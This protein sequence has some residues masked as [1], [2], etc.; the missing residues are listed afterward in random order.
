[1]I[2]G[3]DEAISLLRGGSLFCIWPTQQTQVFLGKGWRAARGYGKRRII[4][5]HRQGKRRRSHTNPIS[6]RVNCAAIGRTALPPSEQA[7]R[8]PSAEQLQAIEVGANGGGICFSMHAGN[9]LP[10]TEPSVRS[11][12]LCVRSPSTPLVGWQ[13]HLRPCVQSSSAIPP[14]NWKNQNKKS[15]RFSLPDLLG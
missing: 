2:E 9:E 3:R 11:G 13:Y 10:V 15:G 5:A 14:N 4:P 6:F 7:Q 1:M 8:N 12:A